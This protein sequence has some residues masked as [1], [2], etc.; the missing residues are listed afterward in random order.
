[1]KQL[2]LF[3]IVFFSIMFLDSILYSQDEEESEDIICLTEIDNFLA[4]SQDTVPYYLRPGFNSALVRK[5][6]V[7]YVDF[8]DGRFDDHG[9]LIQPK[10][11][12]E[13]GYVQNLDAVGEAGVITS[14][15]PFPIGGG[16]YVQAAKYTRNDRWNMWF[17]QGVYYETEHP[18]WASH[19]DSAYGS[20][21]EYW[22]E[23]SN[24]NYTIEPFETHPGESSY[25][26]KTGIVNNYTVLPGGDTV[27]EHITLPLNKYGDNDNVAYFPDSL[28]YSFDNDG[29]ISRMSL[30]M[31]NTESKL[32]SMY[33]L[34]Q[35]DFNLN[36]FYNQG[37]VL[38]VVM[39]GG[40]IKFKGLTHLS[41]N[42]GVFLTKANISPINHQDSR[43]SGLGISAHEFGHASPDLHWGHTNS[44]Q[45]CVMNAY[46]RH[47]K[48]CPAHPNPVYKLRKGWLEAIPLENSQSFDSLP[49][50]ETSKKVGV[51]T[52]YG[53]PTAAGD[54]SAGESYILENRRLTGFD[55][56][57][58][59][60][61]AGSFGYE[62]FKGGLL[63]WKYSPYATVNHVQ[64][65][66]QGLATD[67]KLETPTGDSLLYGSSPVPNYMFA[68]Q[69]GLSGQYYILDSHRTHSSA[70][71]PTG[72]K[73]SNINNDTS[74]FNGFIDFDLTY[75]RGNPL[76][77]DHV[78]YQ[79]NM[80]NTVVNLTGNIYFHSY[81]DKEFYN[82]NE[83]T[84]FHTYR[85]MRYNAL[86]LNGTYGFP[87]IFRGVGYSNYRVKY[88]ANFASSGLYTLNKS[89]SEIDSMIFKHVQ[90]EDLKSNTTEMVIDYLNTEPE[91]PV[92]LDSVEVDYST[93]L[94]VGEIVVKRN[95]IVSLNLTHVNLGLQSP[96]ISCDPVIHNSV[97]QLM[98]LSG[99][100]I[101]VK[102]GHGIILY[103]TQLESFGHFIIKQQ[104][105][106]DS[107]NGITMYGGNIAIGTGTGLSHG[108]A[109]FENALYAIDGDNLVTADIRNSTF[110]NNVYW[111]IS[112]GNS[113]LS[114]EPSGLIKNNTFNCDENNQFAS[115]MLTNY[116]LFNIDS[117]R[118][119]D[120]AET[121]I[122]IYNCESPSVR[123]NIITGGAGS[124]PPIGIMS[125]ASDGFYNCN[126]ITQ[127]GNYGMLITDGTPILLNNRLQYN[128]VGMYLD[129]NSVPYLIPATLPG[130]I[131]TVGG[132]NTISYNAGP[133]IFHITT[134]IAISA[135]E[136]FDGYNIIEDT[137]AYTDTLIYNMAP[138]SNWPNIKCYGNYWGGG[139]PTT[140]LVPSA[141]FDPNPY[142]T[143]VP[144]DVCEFYEDVGDNM[145]SGEEQ[146]Y[147]LGN[148]M[149]NDHIG[150]YEESRYYA[151][152]LL[153]NEENNF[154]K[155][156]ALNKLLS[157]TV[158]DNGDLSGVQHYLQTFSSENT[159]FPDL[160]KKARNLAIESMIYQHQFTQAVNAYTDI[161]NNSNNDEEIFYATLD[162]SR[163]L[164]LMLDSLLDKRN[165]SLNANARIILDNF[166][167]QTPK[168]I[169]YSDAP[170]KEGRSKAQ[171]EL[172]AKN[173]SKLTN[174][175]NYISKKIANVDNMSTNELKRLIFEKT[176][177]DLKIRNF[178]PMM[179]SIDG[180]LALRKTSNTEIPLTF[181]LEQNY[182][183]PFNPITTIRYQ[184][185]KDELVKLKVYDVLGREVMTLVNTHL[186]TGAYEITFNATNFASGVYFYRIEA[187][188]FVETKRMMLVK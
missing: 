75:T 178:N 182:P 154:A 17:S 88:G 181:K 89:Y 108:N 142:L 124:V 52:I 18:D 42:S 116:M 49:P 131:Y 28:N 173:L 149:K 66:E 39:A 145:L 106:D 126:T 134:N 118:F 188:N 138:W 175:Q 98:N 185:P 140:R 130:S 162:R 141:Y 85:N 43:I 9:T 5:V 160:S 14:S 74:S 159:E 143:S 96:R 151:N 104:D 32:I 87:I 137:A 109:T 7:V 62:N 80:S 12:T 13:L 61:Y 105:G 21:Y 179:P 119:N 165:I 144:I 184:I 112:L 100:P 186:M 114:A 38:I 115:V 122:L 70:Y 55:R 53:K 35:I 24:N 110:N 68:Y 6:A 37:G 158:L 132:Y 147:V 170:Q 133:E 93:A 163:V 16:K 86:E 111:D 65:P 78:V 77:Y 22:K 72:I 121:G 58:C 103:D 63:I 97:L 90:F 30:V 19:G 44:S 125:Y 150:N 36:S 169:H 27:V 81:N 123:K 56:K 79:K 156:L 113:L 34:S 54:A 83:G 60:N 59:P 153:A 129:W 10:N 26:L 47:Y 187:G 50:V 157:G 180:K 57:L 155:T 29:D 3:L 120:I 183:N 101:K 166:F 146:M 82:V 4:V 171:N 71:L 15:T 117:N 128:G 95:N 45:F 76:V 48:D 84:M 176:I 64:P 102:Q 23:V 33:N 164:S 41:P 174:L 99:M 161:I 135:P 31:D 127:C 11:N 69:K 168:S 67:I 94:S 46:D 107:W 92:I 51:I 8:P 139:D 20:F 40:H 152:Q 25:H 1:M 148:M 91:L 2:H 73:I 172:V 136:L 167:K 177:Y